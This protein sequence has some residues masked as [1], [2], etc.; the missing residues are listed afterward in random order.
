MCL[1]HPQLQE[2]QAKETRNFQQINLRGCPR[3]LPSPTLNA[4][5]KKPN[6]NAPIPN[7][8]WK[9]PSKPKP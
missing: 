1:C 4:D 6:G 7:D 5:A 8:I 3:N 2:G 9:P